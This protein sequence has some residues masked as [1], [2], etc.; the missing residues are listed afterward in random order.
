ML[1]QEHADHEA[2]RLRRAPLAEKMRR[3]LLVEPGSDD[4]VRQGDERVFHVDD[5]IEAGA[6][7]IV[8]P[9]LLLLFRSHGNPR[10]EGLR[11]NTNGPEN[12]SQNARKRT[13]K[14]RTLANSLTSNQR[15]RQAHQWRQSSS[16]G[17]T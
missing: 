9:R 15:K 7:K 13:L 10:M 16:R 12:E 11:G 3:Q 4:L 2:H 17:T 1:Q 8:M 5:L 6:E 14:S